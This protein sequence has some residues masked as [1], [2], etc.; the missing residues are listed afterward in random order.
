MARKKKAKKQRKKGL[1]RNPTHFYL[2][3]L[4]G[5]A[6]WYAV[7]TVGLVLAKDWY[8]GDPLGTSLTVTGIETSFFAVSLVG[9]AW[10]LFMSKKQLERDFMW[11]GR[12][13]PWITDEGMKRWW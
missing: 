7:P 9:L 13:Q 5:T 4:L 3:D 2:S 10:Y 1:R 12:G 11:G 8:T 6:V